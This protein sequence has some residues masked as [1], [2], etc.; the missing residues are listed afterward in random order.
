MER[1]CDTLHDADKSARLT[2]AIA[3]KGA[4]RRFKDE[5]HPSRRAR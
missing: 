4:F 5:S 2:T 3:G 1:F